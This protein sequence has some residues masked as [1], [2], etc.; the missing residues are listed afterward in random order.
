MDDDKV[1]ADALD[2]HS[3]ARM[4]RAPHPRQQQRAEYPLQITHIDIVSLRK[5]KDIAVNFE[6]RPAS[7]LYALVC[8]DGFSRHC[9]AFFAKDLKEV[10]KLLRFYLLS[11]GSH[12]LYG[13]HVALGDGF[14]EFKLHSD[15]GPQL[16]SEKVE[17]LLVQF[18]MTVSL[19]TAPYTPASDGTAERF[20]QTL[21]TDARFFLAAAGLSPRY[22]TYAVRFACASRNRLA[23]QREIQKDGSIIY[24]TPYELFYGRQ[25]DLRN[26]VA[27]GAP[28]RMLV[29]GPERQQIGKLGL[30]GL[31]GRVLGHGQDGLQM[32][33]GYR[34]SLGWIVL[35]DDGR[36]MLSRNVAIDESPIVGGDHSR[37]AIDGGGAAASCAEEDGGVTS[38]AADDDEADAASGAD[39]MIVEADANTH[40]DADDGA[41]DA[42]V[43]AEADAESRAELTVGDSPLPSTTDVELEEPVE[44]TQV[45]GQD[46]EP[47]GFDPRR[48]DRASRSRTRQMEQAQNAASVAHALVPGTTLQAQ[49]S[50]LMLVEELGAVLAQEEPIFD[51]EFEVIEEQTAGDMFGGKASVL[52]AHATLGDKT[53]ERPSSYKQ[54]MAS[55][56]A[57]QWLEAVDTCLQSHAQLHTF[58]EVIVPTGTHT[59]G[60]RWVPDLKTN[61]DGEVERFKMRF[62]LKGYLQRRGVDFDQVFSPTVR[63]EQLRTLLGI[64]TKLEGFKLRDPSCIFVHKLEGADV[65]DAY[66]TSELGEGEHVLF[67]LPEGYEPK[68]KAQQG[69]KVVARALKAQM[70]LRQS[71]RA[72]W[73]ALRKQLLAHG[74]VPCAA[75]PCVYVKDLGDDGFIVIGHFVDDLMVLNATSDQ[76]AIDKLFKELEG[77]FKTRRLGQLSKFLGAEFERIE[78]GV[79]LHLNQFVTEM[80]GKFGFGN[81]KPVP[82]PE[83]EARDENMDKGLLQRADISLYQQITGSIMF[84]ATTCRPD[85]AHCVNMLARRMAAPRVCDMLAAKRALHYLS[86]TRRAGLLFKYEEDPN[87]PGLAA[88]SDSDW[89]GD[90]HERRSTQ[91]YVVF[92]NGTPISWRSGLQS[93]I[94]LSS[95]EAEYVA[96]SEACREL[97]YLREVAKFL[98]HPQDDPTPLF[99]DNQGSLDL[100]DNPVHHSRSKHIDVKFHYVR[101]AQENGLVKV[102]K[103]HTDDNR[104]DIFTKTTTTS[105]FRR[106]VEAMMYATGITS[107][108]GVGGQ[109]HDVDV[110]GRLRRVSWSDTVGG[111]DVS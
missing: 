77:A 2:T 56:E 43:H 38:A 58:D 10:T 67:E 3:A 6:G 72:W 59:I 34:A 40:A 85:L 8:I 7:A 33:G 100:V 44:L 31:R 81:A 96:L 107:R 45:G 19:T 27:F 28:C 75:A 93:V 94:A 20:I 83:V 71:G 73:M 46:E 84:C 95:C 18:G 14:R 25:P 65:S 60:T 36:V 17:A 26:S 37:F 98:H 9:K 110:G 87:H 41:S 42:E 99:G 90:R 32:D 104:A 88:Y 66:L 39:R 103:V 30:P 13:G 4:H 24:R 82:T 23:S 70:G 105:T 49:A 102:L 11:M 61:A 92:F 29:L 76:D 48:L 15:N 74:F 12:L 86:G 57:V 111:D 63:S 79:H 52:N 97:A 89:A 35:L 101:T 106:H 78:R 62:V 68:L 69:F 109:S 22:W 1:R 108:G 16:I 80:L 47:Q 64:A 53:I 5:N 50:R 51:D 55:P 21:I 91:G 54:A